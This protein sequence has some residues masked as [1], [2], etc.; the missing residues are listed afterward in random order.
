MR[1]RLVSVR[2]GH[3]AL[4][5]KG[6][7]RPLART[8]QRRFPSSLSVM[9]G[10]MNPGPGGEEM[11][12]RPLP[13]RLKL[14]RRRPLAHDDESRSVGVLEEVESQTRVMQ[15]LKR[16]ALP[17]TNQRTAGHSPS[18]A[19]GHSIAV[20]AV[21]VRRETCEPRFGRCVAP[22][23]AEAADRARSQELVSS[24]RAA[25]PRLLPTDAKRRSWLSRGLIVDAD[26]PIRISQQTAV[27][28]QTS[29]APR[30]GRPGDGEGGRIAVR[31]KTGPDPSI[32]LAPAG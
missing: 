26:I 22:P 10:G 8:E 18:W 12:S 7:A 17:G 9:R 21:L 30:L 3:Y 13:K 19:L 23:R 29:A 20:R 32:Q 24:G 15:A 4:V 1:Q 27:P 16:T 14:Q 5:D 2:K 31:R 28:R 25:S 11:G 6:S